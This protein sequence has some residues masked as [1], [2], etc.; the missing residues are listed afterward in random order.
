MPDGPFEK[1]Y[2]DQLMSP[3]SAGQMGNEPQNPVTASVPMP[4]YGLL[5]DANPSE[6]HRLEM[7]CGRMSG[8]LIPRRAEF[9]STCAS[10]ATVPV[11]TPADECRGDDALAGPCSH[12]M[13]TS[14]GISNAEDTEFQNASDS[15]VS[16]PV[17][18]PRDGCRG[19]AVLARPFSKILPTFEGISNAGGDEFWSIHDSS[20]SVS[21]D[22]PRNVCRGDAVLAGPCSNTLSTVDG[23]L[24]DGSD[25][26][27]STPEMSAMMTVNAPRDHCRGMLFWLFHAATVC[28]LLM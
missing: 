4:V 28:P 14:R 18:T 1:N 25:E 15:S 9:L 24:I 21:V 6:S 12:I 23:D 3:L 5:G 19:V 22:T 27:R 8:E 7:L 17:E 2:S 16:A 13:S 26:C 10:S 20:T 11:N